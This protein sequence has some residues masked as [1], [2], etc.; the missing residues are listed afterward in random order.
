MA[1]P[2]NEARKLLD[3]SEG[4]PGLPGYRAQRFLAEAPRLL[5]ALAVRA[6]QAD[7]L[8]ARV[9]AALALHGPVPD[10]QGFGSADPGGYGRIDPACGTCGTHGEYATPHPC[11]TYRALLGEGDG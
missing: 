10:G 11:G 8:Q 2:L 5:A 6:E 9:D 3:E 4:M 7:R 1:D